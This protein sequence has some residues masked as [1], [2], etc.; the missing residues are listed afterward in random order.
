MATEWV[1]NS[2]QTNTKINQHKYFVNNKRWHDF[3]LTD[4]LS[5]GFIK[6]VNLLP[7][8]SGQLL[9]HPI[10][11]SEV[12]LSAPDWIFFEYLTFSTTKTE[13]ARPRFALQH[14]QVV[15]ICKPVCFTFSDRVSP[16]SPHSGWFCPR[17]ESNICSLGKK[18]VSRLMLEERM[19]GWTGQEAS[20]GGC[21]RTIKLVFYCLGFLTVFCPSNCSQLTELQQLQGGKK[22]VRSWLWMEKCVAPH[23]GIF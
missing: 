23:T 2:Y 19:V 17:A 18:S 6:S 20:G 15:H 4:Y 14:W 16:T 3:E 9:K 22:N 8:M 11:G 7:T 10:R 1:N 21:L 13:P 5:H 12:R